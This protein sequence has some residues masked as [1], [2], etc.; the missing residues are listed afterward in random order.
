MNYPTL[1]CMNVF[2]LTYVNNEPISCKQISNR[3][4]EGQYTYEYNKGYLIYAIVKAASEEEALKIG[5]AVAANFQQL[6]LLLTNDRKI[7]I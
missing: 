4:I 7:N 3:I 2:K 6:K 5:Q 1:L